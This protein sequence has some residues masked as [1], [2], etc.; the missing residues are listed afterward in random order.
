MDDASWRLPA[1]AL[2]QGS[3]AHNLNVIVTGACRSRDS[4]FEDTLEALRADEAET[5]EW[6]VDYRETLRRAL[7]TD[8]IEEAVLG[9]ADQGLKAEA[10][11]SRMGVPV[12]RTGRAE[13]VG[14][15]D[16]GAHGCSAAGRSRFSG[17]R[18]EPV[19]RAGDVAQHPRGD[20]RVIGG[21]LQLGVPQQ[22]LDD[23]DVD[24]V[25]KQMGGETVS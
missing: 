14:D 21:G 10:Q 3:V 1:T 25:L 12:C 13:D 15:L 2:S 16:G 6:F 23:A 18:G 8:K 24:P 22:R 5:D 4:G 20:L 19:E 11:M 9:A 17:G 7:K